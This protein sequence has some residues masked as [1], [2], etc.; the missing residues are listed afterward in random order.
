MVVL[1]A[2]LA[3]LDRESSELITKQLEEPLFIERN[4]R[5]RI[6]I[7]RFYRVDEMLRIAD[8]KFRDLLVRVKLSQKGVVEWA[9]VTFYKGRLFSIEFKNSG[10][11]YEDS[12]IEIETVEVGNAGA[13]YAHEIDK[14]EHRVSG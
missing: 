4:H 3:V 5:G 1:K 12:E 9:H 7:L 10:H 6:N 8:P 2:V 11:F 14:A 13:S